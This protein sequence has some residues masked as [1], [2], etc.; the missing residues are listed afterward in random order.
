[1]AKLNV[2]PAIIKRENIT[3]SWTFFQNMVGCDVVLSVAAPAVLVAALACVG[4][5]GVRCRSELVFGLRAGS[6]LSLEGGCDALDGTSWLRDVLLFALV[7]ERVI[8]GDKFF[9]LLWSSSAFN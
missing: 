1:M 5:A 2:N 8:I 7:F 9:K 4:A 3:R 6:E